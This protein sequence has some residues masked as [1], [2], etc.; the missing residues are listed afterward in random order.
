MVGLLNLA[1]HLFFLIQI[2]Q[3]LIFYMD[4]QEYMP[5]LDYVL[6]YFYL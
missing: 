1:M 6:F 2:L 3:L 5:I 4:D